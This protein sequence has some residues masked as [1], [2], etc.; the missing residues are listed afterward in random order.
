MNP[1]A[2]DQQTE[3]IKLN[4]EMLLERMPGFRLVT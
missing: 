4:G 2:T 1:G 3:L